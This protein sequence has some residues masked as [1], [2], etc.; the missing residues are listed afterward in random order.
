MSS[1]VGKAPEGPFTVIAVAVACVHLI[2]MLHK[3]VMSRKDSRASDTDP[4]IVRALLAMF[5]I[6]VRVPVSLL[7]SRTAVVCPA[8]NGILPVGSILEVRQR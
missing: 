4:V 6:F 1:Y 7:A 5:Y 8:R 3:S 2:V